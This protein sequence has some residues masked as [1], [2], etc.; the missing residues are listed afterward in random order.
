MTRPWWL[1]TCAAATFVAAELI[2]TRLDDDRRTWWDGA[3]ALALGVTAVLAVAAIDVA[4]R[5][6]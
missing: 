3:F 5:Y 1:L 4:T 2:S 6:A